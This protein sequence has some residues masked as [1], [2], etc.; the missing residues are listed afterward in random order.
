MVLIRVDLT[1]AGVDV[2][3]LWARLS[4]GSHVRDHERRVGS[5]FLFFWAG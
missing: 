1:E 3:E 4:K 5:S 2:H